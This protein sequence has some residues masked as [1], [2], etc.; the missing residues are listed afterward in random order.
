MKGDRRW[1]WAAGGLSAGGL[2]LAA[3]VPVG[4]LLIVAA[5]LACPLLMMRGHGGMES[6]DNQKDAARTTG[7]QPS[8]E[9][10]TPVQ[11]VSRT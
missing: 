5:L 7:E 1:L 6:T 3:G 10:P 2:A 8:S 9:R 4:T 11:P